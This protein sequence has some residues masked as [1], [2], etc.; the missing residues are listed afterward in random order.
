M[1]KIIILASAVLFIVTS[2]N[3]KEKKAQQEQEA[4]VKKST[5]IKKASQFLNLNILPYKT[6]Q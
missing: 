2:C 3:Y 1:N 4:D 5:M 6:I